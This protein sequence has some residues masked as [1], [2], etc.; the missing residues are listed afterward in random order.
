MDEEITHAF[1]SQMQ[2]AFCLEYSYLIVAIP[3][4]VTGTLVYESRAVTER[5][6]V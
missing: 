5:F 3:L 4:C 2:L 6:Y 1:S